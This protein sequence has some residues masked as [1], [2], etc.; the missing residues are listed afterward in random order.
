[1]RALPAFLLQGKDSSVASSM[2]P[3]FTG[4]TTS[5]CGLDDP[6]AFLLL[7]KRVK[8]LSKKISIEETMVM[9]YIVHVM[10]CMVVLCSEHELVFGVLRWSIVLS[11]SPSWCE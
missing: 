3:N 11:V 1:M 2:C 6:V 10:V 8:T 5:R 9:I 7:L 4:Q